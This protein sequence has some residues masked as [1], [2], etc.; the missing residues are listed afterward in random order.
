MMVALSTFSIET[1]KIA[2]LA[3]VR[4]CYVCNPIFVLL[5]LFFRVLSVWC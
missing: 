4:Q 2:I 1:N 5:R 3:S